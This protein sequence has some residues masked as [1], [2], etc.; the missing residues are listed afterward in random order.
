MYDQEDGDSIGGKGKN[1]VNARKQSSRYNFTCDV[2]W[3]KERFRLGSPRQM[4]AAQ[5]LALQQLRKP[6]NV[7][8]FST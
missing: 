8:Y 7:N 6:E 3:P 5:A 2:A 1:R 4:W